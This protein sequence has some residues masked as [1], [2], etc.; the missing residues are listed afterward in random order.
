MVDRSGGQVLGVGYDTPLGPD[1]RPGSGITLSP[2]RSLIDLLQ[3]LRGWR[4]RLVAGEGS[5]VEEHAGRLVGVDVAEEPR[6]HR[7]SIVAVLNEATGA[8]AAVA[9]HLVRR[10][11]LLEERATA[12][13]SRFLDVSRGKDEHRTATIRLSP[14]EHDLAVSYVV[15][16]PTWRVSYRIVVASAPREGAGQPAMM[17]EA[18]LQLQ[19]WGLF[20]NG[21]EEDLDAVQVMLV[22]GQPISFIYDLAASH[23]PRRPV[24]RDEGRVAAG[25]VEFDAFQAYGASSGMAR[26][27]ASGN[28][29]RVM[30][31]LVPAMRMSR[32]V[33]L[34]EVAQQEVAATG[35]ELGELF[36]YQVTAPVTAGEAPTPSSPSSAAAWPAAANSCSTEQATGASRPGA[37][38]DQHDR[39]GARTGPVTVLEDGAYRGEAMLPF[40]R[41]GAEVDLAYLV[42]LGIRITVE[43][44]ERTKTAGID[45]EGDAMTVKQAALRTTRYHID[46]GL[47]DARRITVE[48]ASLR[49]A[50][51]ADT[52]PPDAQTRS[53]IVASVDAV[54]RRVTLFTVAERRYTWQSSQIFD[55]A[56]TA[57]QETRCEGWLDDALLRAC[58]ASFAKRAAVADNREEIKRL[59]EERKEIFA[60][61]GQISHNLS[62]LATSGDAGRCGSEPWRSCSRARSARRHPGADCRAAEENARRQA[63]IED[64]LATLRAE[65]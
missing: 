2:E 16:S 43:T 38:L 50:E 42:E 63:A 41:E 44:S 49:D 54:A 13:L 7:D 6:L 52:P 47:P 18:E 9:L 32:A 36:Q 17:D 10:V 35:S 31:A 37:A 51:L 45:L 59:N 19:G 3:T 4:I 8:I 26:E 46:N 25:P 48:H 39:A 5:A 55:Y 53:S 61:E 27:R 56:Y 33:S 28:Q 15:P 29:A 14:G 1:D 23:V 12:D 40:S 58:R 62:A 20:D 22:A 30:S 65:G 11:D 24:V 60:R 57:L 34:A 21:L 64:H